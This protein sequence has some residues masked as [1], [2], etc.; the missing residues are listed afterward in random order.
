MRI[1]RVLGGREFVPDG[2]RREARPLDTSLATKG[3]P[4]AVRRAGGASEAFPSRRK[5]ILPVD[6]TWTRWARRSRGNTLAFCSRR[7]KTRDAGFKWTCWMN[8]Y[9]S[10]REWAQVPSKLVHSI[11]FGLGH[12]RPA[13]MA[14]P[15][16]AHHRRACPRGAGSGARAGAPQRGP[17][18]SSSG[19]PPPW[20]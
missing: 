14:P 18:S 13:H 3:R 11:S 12:E 2:E 10:P 16:A 19:S 15:S 9:A 6:R 8:W 4:C 7:I 20:R 17:R 5:T 1:D